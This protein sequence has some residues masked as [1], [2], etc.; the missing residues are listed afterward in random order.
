MSSWVPLQVED[1][2]V[3]IIVILKVLLYLSK[4]VKLWGEGPCKEMKGSFWLPGK[5]VNNNIF[6]ARLVEDFV[7]EPE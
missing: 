5:I 2:I 7:M 1:N 6:S 3:P 4:D